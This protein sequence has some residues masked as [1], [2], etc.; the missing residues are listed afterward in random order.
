MGTSVPSEFTDINAYMYLHIYIHISSAG[1]VVWGYDVRNSFCVEDL[2]SIAQPIYTCVSD[3]S[4]AIGTSVQ[5]LIVLLD[6][7]ANCPSSQL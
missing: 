3:G 5:R 6:K 4:Q 2:L 7:L 1:G